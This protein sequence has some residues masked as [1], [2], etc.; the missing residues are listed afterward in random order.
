MFHLQSIWNLNITEFLE[1]KCAFKTSSFSN[2]SYLFYVLLLFTWIFVRYEM[3]SIEQK[4]IKKEKERR[5]IRPVVIVFK[6]QGRN[7]IWLAFVLLSRL[8]FAFLLYICVYCASLGK[9]GSI[10]T[11][12]KK[13]CCGIASFWCGLEFC[14]IFC[15]L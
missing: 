6:I 2:H 13:G 12:R 1:V 7:T 15:V 8:H 3:V 11:H 4:C 5:D 9:H 10:V 14:N